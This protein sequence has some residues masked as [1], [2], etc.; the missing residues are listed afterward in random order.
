MYVSC[1]I[2]TSLF[3]YG[4]CLDRL[5]PGHDL[6]R[7]GFI[8]KNATEDPKDPPPLSY[9]H[10]S[11]ANRKGQRVSW[12]GFVRTGTRAS[13]VPFEIPQRRYFSTFR[14]HST[15][16]LRAPISHQA[17]MGREV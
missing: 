11:P 6:L 17:E 16:V 2:A 10:L 1:S 7:C 15:T 9:L 14:Q 8:A 12:R 5:P 4:K 3:I 13:C